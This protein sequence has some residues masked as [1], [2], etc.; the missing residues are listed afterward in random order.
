MAEAFDTPTYIRGPLRTPRQMLAEQEYGG[1]LSI[2]DDSTA[3]KMGF[4]AGGPIE[5]PTH[6]SQFV[7]LLHDLWGQEWFET[8]CLSAHYRNMVV[9]GEQVRAFVEQPANGQ[10]Q[11]RVRAE[12]EDGTEVLIGTASIR[13][14]VESSELATRMSRLRPP[15]PLVVLR[16]L[17]VGMKGKGLEEVRMD[18][19]QNMGKLYPFSLNQKLDKITE[20]SPWYTA[21][22]GASSPWGR[23]IIPLEMVSVLA[24]YSNRQAG[25]PTRGPALGLFAGQQIRMIDGPLFVGQDYLLE[26]EIVALSESRRTESNWVRTTFLD[27]RSKEPRAEMILNNATLKHSFEGYEEERAAYEEERAAMA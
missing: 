3:E 1:H 14:D 2:H 13:G 22:E 11:V 26:R 5:G 10:T 18:F 21:D 25:F 23:A 4:Q 20:P 16:D 15:G 8:G 12:K 19:D 6:F 9:E 27:A 17:E 7:P 24:G